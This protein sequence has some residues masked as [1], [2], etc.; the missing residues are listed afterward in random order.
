MKGALGEV[1]SMLVNLLELLLKVLLHPPI[2]D[3]YLSIS[4]MGGPHWDMEPSAGKL[5][6]LARDLNMKLL[7]VP[8]PFL[9]LDLIKPRVVPPPKP[10]QGRKLLLESL[11]LLDQLD[12]VQLF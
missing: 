11:L 9:E 10:L 8:L 5:P 6:L 4:R 1:L 12:K 3:L 7:V 2:E